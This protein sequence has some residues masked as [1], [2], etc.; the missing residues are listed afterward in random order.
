MG[1]LGVRHAR[2]NRIIRYA[3]GRGRESSSVLVLLLA[4]LLGRLWRRRET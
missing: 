2:A 1:D 4:P 3:S